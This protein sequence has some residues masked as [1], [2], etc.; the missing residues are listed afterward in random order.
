M[1][2]EKFKAPPLPQAP[3][4]YRPEFFSQL[5]RAVELYFS[6]LDSLTPNQAQSYRADNFYGGAFT[7][8]N[9]TASGTVTAVAVNA[10]NISASEAFIARQYSRYLDVES[11]HNHNMLTQTLMA[12]DVYA[13]EFYG[14]GTYIVTPYNLITDSN[15]Q[16]A[17]AIDVATAVTYDT[18]N[19]PDGIYIGSPASRI[20][21]STGGIYRFEFSI[22]FQ[23]STNGTQ[24]VDIWFRKNGTDVSASNSQFGLPARRS[25]GDPSS[26][27]AVTP[28]LIDLAAG[29]YMEIMWRPSD[30]G[31]T[32]QTIPAAT[33]SA[34]VTPDIP[35]TPSIILIV[36]FVSATHPP[37]TYVA[38]LPVIG[39]GSVGTVTISTP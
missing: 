20:Y 2:L 26:L 31:V 23:N 8:S 13:D 10:T 17:S 3:D 38:P 21:V 24:S 35:S 4:V 30:T 5:V 14:S 33:Y 9:V 1:A 37:V 28:F 36:S 7:G 34:G 6:Q 32:I 19:F 39:I 16:T 12:S 15:D 22:Q 29:D 18:D 27:L 25:S 11:F